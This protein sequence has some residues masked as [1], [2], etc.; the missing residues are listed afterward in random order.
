MADHS[1]DPDLTSAPAAPSGRVA[2]YHGRLVQ[3][4]NLLLRRA[5]M[6]I[7]PAGRLG[8]LQRLPRFTLRHH[9]YDCFCHR[10]NCGFP[11]LRM[12][13]R[14]LEMAIADRWLKRIGHDRVVETGAVTPYYWPGRIAMVVD[15]YDPHPLVTHRTSLFG[16]DLSGLDVLA[17]STLE[18]IGVGDYGPVGDEET[19]VHALE[20]I[21][22]ESRRF[23][24]SVPYGFN[25]AVDAT[26]FSNYRFPADVTALCMVR[27]EQGNDW[28]ESPVRAAAIP[29]GTCDRHRHSANSVLIVERG[30]LL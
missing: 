10:Y 22:R 20:K 2:P 5:G 25:P 13:E 3:S 1:A 16:T 7:V 4:A 19:A 14:S 11:P 18:H 8:S 29:Y 12:T 15:P 27:S 24:V 28:R 26:L 17:I 23:L 9:R 6:A 30:G 21:C